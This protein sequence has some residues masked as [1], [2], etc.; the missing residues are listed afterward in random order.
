VSS[1]TAATLQRRCSDTAATQPPCLDQSGISKGLPNGVGER[2]YGQCYIN[3]KMA[4]ADFN[5]EKFLEV[6]RDH[7]IIYK[8]DANKREKERA[9]SGVLIRLYE[10]Y[11]DLASERKAELG[12]YK[13]ISVIIL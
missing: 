12:K 8:S 9:W 3:S 2:V 10:G 5:V 13:L 7:P 6:V 4:S 11:A 1:D